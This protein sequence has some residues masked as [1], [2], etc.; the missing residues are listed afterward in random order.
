MPRPRELPRDTRAL[1]LI[2]VTSQTSGADIHV[3]FGGIKASSL[4][5]HEQVRAAVELY[6]DLVTLYV[7]AQLH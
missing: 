5:P 3:P 2:H 4:G 1:R 7:D 6:T